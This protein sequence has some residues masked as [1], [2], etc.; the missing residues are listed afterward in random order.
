M[1]KRGLLFTFL[2]VLHLPLAGQPQTTYTGSNI[3]GQIQ[4]ARTVNLRQIAQST[5]PA[6]TALRLSQ[7]QRMLL[8][9]FPEFRPPG[10][11]LRPNIDQ[12]REKTL[13]LAENAGLVS[14]TTVLAVN[15]N[16][17]D[18]G[19]LGLTHRDQR[20]ANN[21]NQYSIEPPSQSIAV[22]NGFILEGVNNAVQ[23]YTEAGVPQL[24]RVLSSNEVFGLRP[25]VDRTTG[26]NG[27]FPTDMRV[28]FDQTINRW[29]I[30]QRA[31]D[32]NV[33]G[34]P[35][36]SSHLYFA[37]SQTPDPTAAYNV[38]QMDT[39]DQGSPGCPCVFD[40]PQIGADRY[41]FHISVNRYTIDRFNPAVLHF[42]SAAILVISKE[43]L[44]VG[45]SVPT[46]SR[47]TLPFTNG[48]EFALQ[49][50]TTPPGASYFLA[51]GGLQYFVSTNGRS[52][53]D[54]RMAV[55]AM[56][57]T[58]SLSTPNPV[59]VLVQAV[60]P[61]LPYSFPDVV[62]QKPGPL[63]YG[64]S[65]FPPF[66]P[67]FIDGGDLRILSASYAGGRV[68]ATL[69]CRVTD[70]TGRNLVGGAYVVF[71]P[72]LRA[73]TLSAP[74]LGQGYLAVRRNHLLR[75]AI[76]VNSQGRGAISFTLAGPDHFPGAAYTTFSISSPGT[77]LHVVAPGAAP[78][79]GFTGYDGGGLARWGD[80][81]G[82]FTAP[83][84]SIWMA[85]QY[86]PN[87]PRSEA[88]NWGTYL[89]RYVP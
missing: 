67:A 74:V 22:A 72:S 52:T 63:P 14:P 6:R 79:D 37:V 10:R 56:Y 73:G 85:M 4:L 70:D 17:A 27:E 29:I 47:F 43:A 76:A 32:Y 46:A 9:E 83:D 3:T 35:I 38:Y 2:S 80:Y 66:S 64:S 11:L 82:A 41:G 25:A 75:P 60:V 44:G 19:F 61:T 30:L 57:N 55:W 28:F 49:P 54:N 21:G 68:F 45:V 39:T 86:I 23:V 26:I 59:P 20:L 7:R 65:F 8:D 34:E 51:N 81:S 40:F 89:T 1:K 88:A 5:T 24:A 16:Q 31:Q 36:L 84:G 78:Q 42:L 13:R 58:S 15:I 12:K 48:Y 18:G 62:P 77:V 69:A 71:S 87:A 33:V 50:A 53:S